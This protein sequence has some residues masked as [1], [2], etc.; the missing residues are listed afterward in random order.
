MRTRPSFCCAL[1][2]RY[3]LV[4]YTVLKLHTHTDWVATMYAHN[5]KI[6]RLAEIQTFNDP[7]ARGFSN[8]PNT[9]DGTAAINEETKLYDTIAI[10]LRLRHPQKPT[11]FLPL[12]ELLDAMCHELAHC[13]AYKP[14]T[15]VSTPVERHDRRGRGQSRRRTSGTT[16][17]GRL[18]EAARVDPC[19][20]SERRREYDERAAKAFKKR[21]CGG[22]KLEESRLVRGRAGCRT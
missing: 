12:E 2:M 18:Q 7:D 5:I 4:S 1:S 9:G 17:C 11:E 15:C 22:S 8:Y 16:G 21:Y 14:R 10:G 13:L 20:K 6:H 3:W 19:R